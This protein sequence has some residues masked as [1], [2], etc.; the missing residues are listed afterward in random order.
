MLEDKN[1]D[2]DQKINP[3]KEN[4]NKKPKRK[5]HY[6]QSRLFFLTLAIGCILGLMLPLRPTKSEVEKRNLSEFPKLT[7]KS[8]VDGEFFN[9]LALWYADTFPFRD[10]LIS[11]N[12]QAKS[13]YGIKDTQIVTNTKKTADDIPDEIPND[14]KDDDKKDGK[15]TKL[16]E[17]EKK[18]KEKKDKLEAEKALEENLDD[19]TIFDKPE[20]AGD[21]YITGDRGFSLYYFNKKGADMYI[22]L[23]DKIQEQLPGVNVYDI[24]APTG[25]G[26]VLDEKV[27]EE[28]GSSNQ[29][30]AIEYI[31][32]GIKEKNP[33]VK[34]VNPFDKLKKHNAEY[35]YFRT[36]HHW[37]QLGAYY[38][39]LEFC[40]AK[41]ID[42]VKLEDKEKVE[43]KGFVG[44]LYS[45]SNQAPALKKNPDTVV[46]YKNKNTNKMMY[47]D[48][49]GEEID[50]PIVADV[51]GWSAGTLYSTFIGGDHMFTVMD[52]PKLDN[53]KNAV[54]IKESY[55][56]AFAP[57]LLDH[58]DKVFVI[59]YRYFY[60]YDK[61]N[62]DL[63]RFIKENSVE[64]VILLN[65]AE[66]IT[67]LRIK[68]MNS[69][70]SK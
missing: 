13:L 62:N 38:T 35:L 14:K 59:D 21:V 63:V 68:Q 11:L 53:G 56:N 6:L 4:I 15:D 24:I 2:I 69:M 36:D 43:F 8:F 23:L 34:V 50:W 7:A 3:Q 17:A 54:F 40:R 22:A 57:F 18:E 65:N 48:D 1:K 16:S 58:Y 60:K 29:K 33:K 52:N 46:A 20:V 10:K 55:G 41:G 26:I 64:D 12:T 47:V 61:Y 51:N 19:G 5:K 37:T 30:K 27:Q 44:T 31:E 42:P 49:N 45:S 70:F 32:S 9:K 28:I 25:V 66:A 67:Q 39:Y